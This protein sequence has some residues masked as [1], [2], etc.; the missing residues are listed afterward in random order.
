[1]GGRVCEPQQRHTAPGQKEGIDWAYKE[2][3]H[4]YSNYWHLQTHFFNKNNIFLTTKEYKYTVVNT[5]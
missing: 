2:K 1:M 5:G 3:I 4:S